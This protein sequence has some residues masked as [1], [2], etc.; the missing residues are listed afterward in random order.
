MAKKTSCTNTNLHKAK[1]AKND[2]F[3]TK[4]SDIENE[5]RNYKHHFNGKVVLCNCDESEHTNFYKYFALNF[6][7]L[8]LK[9]LICV[10]YRTNRV[11]E[12]HILERTADN[13]VNEYNTPLKGHGDFRDQESIDFLK[14]ADIVVTNPP[15]SLFRE[16]VAQLVEYD[17]KFLIIGSMNAISYK[18]IFPLLKNNKLWLGYNWPKEFIQPDGTPKK[19]GNIIWFT[20]LDT[21]KRHE[22]L[23]TGMTY[24]R[25]IKKGLYQKYDNYDAINV[26]KLKD[27]PTDYEGVMGVPISFL[28][29]HNP[30]QYEIIGSFSTY[31][32]EISEATN[33]ALIPGETITKIID[34]KIKKL[35]GPI[36]NGKVLYKRLLIK[37]ITK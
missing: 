15:F 19:F 36:I 30:E 22:V 37:K 1:N 28:D 12:V 20:N 17:K 13:R 18:E 31:S 6:M 11:A 14:E 16:F 9:K 4:L 33:G 2:E 35:C 24:E 27:I 8:N 34:G 23:F 21:A 7:V 10:G 3:Y 29:K 32:K 26:D 5:L 25:G